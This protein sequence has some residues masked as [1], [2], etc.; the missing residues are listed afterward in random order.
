MKTLS[1]LATAVVLLWIGWAFAAPP[2]T[3]PA[4]SPATASAKI[5]IPDELAVTGPEIARTRATGEQVY[6]WQADTKTW[7]L[8]G[9]DATFGGGGVQ[10]RHYAGPTWESDDGSKIVG[11]K[12]A[13]HAS[14]DPDAVPWLLMEA[15]SHE[16][17]GVFEKVTFIQRIKTAGGNPPAGPGTAD[18]QEERVQYAATYVFYGPGATTRP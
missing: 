7:K 14:P 12:L 11:K 1:A 13:E 3:P 16:G 8:Q 5:Q 15:A 6:T 10:G 4:T 18:G 9:P 17:T 2:A